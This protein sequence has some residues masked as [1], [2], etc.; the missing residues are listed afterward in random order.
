MIGAPELGADLR[1]FLIEGISSYERLEALLL[2]RGHRDQAW[3]PAIVAERLRI[4]EAVA[5]AVLEELHQATLLAVERE[6]GATRF[7]YAPG[8]AALND[9]VE[10]LAEVY[11]KHPLDVMQIMSAGAIER[12][13]ARAL[14][15]F[16]NAFLLGRRSKQDG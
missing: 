8:T 16:A 14:H 13:R 7:R 9:L 12:V 15:T 5:G 6:P 1:A 10:R 11:A 3:S 2:L 4:T